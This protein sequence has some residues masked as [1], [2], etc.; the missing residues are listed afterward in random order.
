MVLSAPGTPPTIGGSW[1]PACA[2]I[3]RARL[4][5]T[6]V[7]RG[8]LPSVMASR[9][10]YAAHRQPWLALSRSTSRSH[11]GWLLRQ[12]LRTP[13]GTHGRARARLSKFAHGRLV[14]RQAC[15][16]VHCGIKR[17]ALAAVAASERSRIHQLAHTAPPPRRARAL[18][19]SASGSAPSVLAYCL[20]QPGNLHVKMASS[21]FSPL[22]ALAV[23]SAS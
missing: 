9:V 6:G 10:Q 17:R 14:Q 21:P 13:A 19:P 15:V 7:V 22:A 8:S 5:P 23:S 18:D 4:A 1:P 12:C 16:A 11:S 20:V 2:M 3:S